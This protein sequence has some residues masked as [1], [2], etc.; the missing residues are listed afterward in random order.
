MIPIGERERER[1]VD[2]KNPNLKMELNPIMR[3]H[4]HYLKIYC[5]R[6]MLRSIQKAH[7]EKKKRVQLTLTDNYYFTLTDFG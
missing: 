1:F 6:K 3:K 7:K 4:C 2:L 5:R